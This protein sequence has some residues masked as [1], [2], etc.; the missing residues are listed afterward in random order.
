M[1]AAPQLTQAARLEGIS[2]VVAAIAGLT[3]I[4]FHLFA[5]LV[6]VHISGA[7]GDRIEY[8]SY[9]RASAGFIG[10][11]PLG[12]IALCLCLVS[13][14]AIGYGAYIHGVRQAARG[15][16]VLWSGTVLW[17]TGTLAT[18]LQVRRGAHRTYP[19]TACRRTPHQLG[20]RAPDTACRS[21]APAQVACSRSSP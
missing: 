6:T 5:P 16:I 12:F 13:L 20:S 18:P 11:P 10:A 14:L 3:S 17:R 1:T 15:R 19:R 9:W 7:G 21:A 4:G 2:G 8:W